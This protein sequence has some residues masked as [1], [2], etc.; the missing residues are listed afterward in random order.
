MISTEPVITG[1]RQTGLNEQDTKLLLRSS[2]Q[3][4]GQYQPGV[5]PGHKNIG[6]NRKTTAVSKA[7]QSMAIPSAGTFRP[8]VIDKSCPT[9]LIGSR[10]RDHT[11]T[12]DYGVRA[13][14]ASRRTLRA[15][16]IRAHQDSGCVDG[17]RQ[18]SSQ[19]R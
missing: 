11:R 15:E 5:G 12:F 6:T 13:R 9:E 4:Y 14:S 16:G 7:L 17:S 8:T 18:G 3:K 2:L 1:S 19:R 10:L